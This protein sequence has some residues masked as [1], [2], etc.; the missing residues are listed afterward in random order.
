MEP[1]C[2]V[3]AAFA[4]ISRGILA[5]QRR[6][7]NDGILGG[8]TSAP[9]RCPFPVDDVGGS[10]AIRKDKE[11][12]R[13]SITAKGFDRLYPATSG[14]VPG[15]C[16]VAIGVCRRT[17]GRRR[18][19]RLQRPPLMFITVVGAGAKSKW[20]RPRRSAPGE[21]LLGETAIHR[22]PISPIAI[23]HVSPASTSSCERNSSE[24]CSSPLISSRT[25]QPSAPV[26]CVAPDL[27][28]RGWDFPHTVGKTAQWRGA[29]QFIAAASVHTLKNIP[30]L[31]WLARVFHVSRRN[32]HEMMAMTT[33]T[34]RSVDNPG[35]RSAPILNTSQQ[36]SPS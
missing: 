24:R 12:E 36:R 5:R 28:R 11:K 20:L 26:V 3:H 35:P 7:P 21:R 13:W 19:A 33:G 22:Q 27:A 10:G 15:T 8:P 6:R 30:T 25:S 29:F 34:T 31:G 17:A 32:P 16:F 2:R 18:A 23:F 14:G 9:A 1:C 4:A